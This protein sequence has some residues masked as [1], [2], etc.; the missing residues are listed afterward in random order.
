MQEIKLSFYLKVYIT[1]DS[2]SMGFVAD[3]SKRRCEESRYMDGRISLSLDHWNR[4]LSL[5]SRLTD[6]TLYW[7]RLEQ[8]GWSSAWDGGFCYAVKFNM[9]FVT[10]S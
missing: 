8:D 7:S 1:L 2:A 6:D 4:V 10:L 5:A 9:K 3:G